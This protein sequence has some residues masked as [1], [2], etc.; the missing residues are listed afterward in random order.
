MKGWTPTAKWNNPHKTNEKMEK[1]QFFLSQPNKG[2]TGFTFP[3][4]PLRM[5]QC[6]WDVILIWSNIGERRGE[7]Q[8]PVCL[9]LK[10]IERKKESNNRLPFFCPLN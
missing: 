5:P 8:N 4:F 1:N 3:S 7:F 6:K 2:M 10:L 9:K